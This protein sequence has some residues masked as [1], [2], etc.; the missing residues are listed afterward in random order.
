MVWLWH[1]SAN[2][3]RRLNQCLPFASVTC[4][5]FCSQLE[6]KFSICFFYY[7]TTANNV[8]KVA[9]RSHFMTIRLNH[10]STK[11]TK[12]VKINT[13][14]YNNNKLMSHTHF[15]AT[16]I[17]LRYEHDITILMCAQK[18][19]SSQLSL[20]SWKF[21][22]V[23]LWF[24]LIFISVFSIK[25]YFSISKIHYL[26]QYSLT[27]NQNSHR[28]ITQQIPFSEKITELLA[29]IQTVLHIVVQNIK[30]I[31]FLPLKNHTF[32]TIYKHQSSN[33]IIQ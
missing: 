20:L 28:T 8:T 1:I 24:Q 7:P 16:W 31:V 29:C 22:N 33:D 30:P 4:G 10:N 27:P 2:H 3:L 11:I 19:T 23:W 26:W 12:V 32:N 18:L 13:K 9:V 5:Y 15:A 21:E 25:I 14:Y 17:Q 6:L